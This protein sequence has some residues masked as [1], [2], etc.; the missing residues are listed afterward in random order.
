VRTLNLEN[1]QF[2][3]IKKIKVKFESLRK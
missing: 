1:L 3:D 2:E